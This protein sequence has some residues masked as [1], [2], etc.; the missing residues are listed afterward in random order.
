[1]GNDRVVQIFIVAGDYRNCDSFRFVVY[2]Y[3]D[4]GGLQVLNLLF[5]E[6]LTGFLLMGSQGLLDVE[7]ISGFG[8]AHGWAATFFGFAFG[9]TLFLG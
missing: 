8:F 5:R 7:V 6:F 9:V 3:Q 4:L 2:F 1:M